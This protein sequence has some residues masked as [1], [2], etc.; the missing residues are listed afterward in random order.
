[1]SV[2]RSDP[3]GPAAPVTFPAAAAASAREAVFTALTL[4]V[5]TLQQLVHPLDDALQALVHIQPHLLLPEQGHGVSAA[6]G[7][8]H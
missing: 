5:L 1:M 4:Q 7:T 3:V 2:L 8:E 6:G